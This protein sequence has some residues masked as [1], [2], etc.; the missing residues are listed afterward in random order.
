MKAGDNIKAGVLF[1]SQKGKGLKD[2]GRK[3]NWWRW[4]YCASTVAL[5][6]SPGMRRTKLRSRH[7]DVWMDGWMELFTAALIHPESN[8]AAVTERVPAGWRPQQ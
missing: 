4:A 8:G 7:V 1:F 5:Y 6:W 3:L 2:S